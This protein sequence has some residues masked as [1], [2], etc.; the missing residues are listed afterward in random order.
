MRE[1]GSTSSDSRLKVDLKSGVNLYTVVFS[2]HGAVLSPLIIAEGLVQ[3]VVCFGIEG[4]V[5]RKSV[6]G[7]YVQI[8]HAV[9]IAVVK[10][11]FTHFIDEGRCKVVAQAE[12]QSIFLKIERCIGCMLR[13]TRQAQILFIFASFEV[14]VL[15][16]GVS[17]GV[18]A[19]KTDTF[20]GRSDKSEITLVREFH[21]YQIGI[22]RILGLD[23]AVV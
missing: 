9:V 4:V 1:D 22:T 13:R 10:G 11:V 16:T 8:V 5:F 19:I 6:T 21:T 3:Q 7:V 23:K 14:E 15:H 18:S 20:Q 2:L 17:E 12:V